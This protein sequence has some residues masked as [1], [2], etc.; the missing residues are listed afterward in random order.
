MGAKT[1]DERLAILRAREIPGE[2]REYISHHVRNGLVC[3]MGVAAKMKDEPDAA[4][5]ELEWY[6]DHIA[7]DL[8]KIGL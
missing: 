8:K 7:G 2:C 1:D 5:R 4:L 6:I 3:I